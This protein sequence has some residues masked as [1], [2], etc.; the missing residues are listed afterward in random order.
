MER[1]VS[2]NVGFSTLLIPLAL[3]E[4][5]PPPIPLPLIPPELFLLFHQK[6]SEVTSNLLQASLLCGIVFVH[7]FPLKRV[8]GILF[9]KFFLNDARGCKKFTVIF[10]LFF[11][12]MAKKNI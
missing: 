9:L 12:Q 8:V 5:P 4:L 3:L 11:F 6:D 1:V 7:F 2:S 10:F